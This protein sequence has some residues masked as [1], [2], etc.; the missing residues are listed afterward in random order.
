MSRTK[1]IEKRWI[2]LNSELFLD[3]DFDEFDLVHF[4]LPI[5]YY[6]IDTVKKEEVNV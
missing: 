5:A 2:F 4:N 3:N 6:G 1:L